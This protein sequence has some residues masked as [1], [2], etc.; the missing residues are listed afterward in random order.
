ML[1]QKESNYRTEREGEQRLESWSLYRDGKGMMC[2]CTSFQSFTL[3]HT[4]T[5][6]STDTYL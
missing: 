4:C 1:R 2:D 6:Y 5:I 3:Q